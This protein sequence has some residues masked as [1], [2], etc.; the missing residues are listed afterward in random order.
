M[1]ELTTFVEESL[2]KHCDIADSLSCSDQEVAYTEKMRAKSGDDVAKELKRLDDMLKGGA[3]MA[4]DKKTW[5]V[6]RLSILKQM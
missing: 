3:K 5:M 1:G 4:A 2:S 6:Q